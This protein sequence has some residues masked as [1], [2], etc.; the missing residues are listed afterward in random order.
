MF[1]ELTGTETGRFRVKADDFGEVDSGVVGRENQG[2]VGLVQSIRSR[3]GAGSSRIDLRGGKVIGRQSGL[4]LSRLG[5]LK[6][7]KS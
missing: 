2:G 3:G 1:F 4:G 5:T 6:K 7:K